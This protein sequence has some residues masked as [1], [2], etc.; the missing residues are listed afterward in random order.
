MDLL[1]DLD[2]AP[3]TTL[4]RR[5]EHALREAVRSGRLAPGTRLPATRTLAAQLGVSRGVVVD[6]YAQLAAEGYLLTRR[7]GGTTVAPAAGGGAAAGGGGPPAAGGAAGSAAAAAGGAGTAG[8]AAGGAGLAAAAARGAGTAAAAAGGAGTA[9][10]A[11]GGAGAAGG[12]AARRGGA[13][14]M[15]AVDAIGVLRY[16]LRPALPAL[17]GFPRRAWLAAVGR[18]LRGL[19]DERLGY[20]AAAGA[21]ELRATLAAY[22]G[23]V[24]GVRTEP[25]RIV[26]TSG[27]R[28]GLGLLWTALAAEGARRVALEQPGWRGWRQTAAAAGLEVVPLAVDDDGAALDRVAASCG[29]AVDGRA[30]GAAAPGGGAPAGGAPGGGGGAVGGA[31][32]LDALALDAIG[33]SPAHQ[34]PTGAVLSPARRSAA[35]AWAQRGGGLIVEDDYDAEFRYDRSPVGSLQGLAPDVVAYGG[36]AS[37]TL[38]PAVR[39]GWLALPPALVEPV[40]RLQQRLGGAPAVLD[41]LAL[42]DLIERGE[43]DRHLRRQRRRYRR[44]RD[45]LL[46]ALAR[47]LPEVAVRGAAAGLHAVLLLPPELDARRVVS[48]ARERGVALDALGHGPPALLVGYA[49]VDEHAAGPAVAALAAALEAAARPAAA[50]GAAGARRAGGSGPADAAPVGGGA[51]AAGE[52]GRADA[53][54]LGGGARAAG[55]TGRAGVR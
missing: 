29:A 5:A 21:P 35:V 28:Q 37:K 46:A 27:F 33:L 12:G 26:V 54:P 31:A 55:E 50:V 16:D 14:A 4:R 2:A 34:Y 41:Q 20:P 24:R 45:A 44:R 1:L 11:A 6:A 32:A 30:R 51:R 42:A 38:A 39:L 17:D 53:A 10:A 7:G 40:A 48:A 15:R 25:E 49:N 36:T 3:G 43:L 23:R 9:A 13:A 8:A 47:E 22:L 52:T 19:P 18:A